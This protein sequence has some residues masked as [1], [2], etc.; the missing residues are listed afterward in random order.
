ME[1]NGQ[2]CDEQNGFRKDR[3]CTDHIFVL[4]SLV[5]SK[6]HSKQ[7]IFATFIDFR[8]AFDCIDS[9]F[10]LYKILEKG[11]DGNIYW[12]IKSLYRNNE[13]CVMVN[14]YLTDLFNCSY[15]V[16]QG[17]TFSP[18]LFSLY[19]NDLVTCINQLIKGL[20][21]SEMQVSILLYADDVV[22]VAENEENL[23][24]MLNCLHEWSV[25]WK[26]SVNESN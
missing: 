19:I 11:I 2:I 22:L 17:G 26:I 8:K 9:E 3:S 24:D 12:A 25:K 18:T 23:Q 13:A 1:G 14:H 4:N 10:L 16:R 20:H 15:G 7:H 21:L 5:Q 6:I